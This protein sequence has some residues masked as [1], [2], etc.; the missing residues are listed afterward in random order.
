[1]AEPGRLALH[2]VRHV[3][4]RRPGDVLEHERQRG[5]ADPRDRLGARV[6]HV[7]QLADRPHHARAG[8]R[9]HRVLPAEHPRHRRRGHPRAGRHV[10]DGAA[11]RVLA[12]PGHP[13]LPSPRAVCAHPSGSAATRRATGSRTEASSGGGEGAGRRERR[14][15][16]TRPFTRHRSVSAIPAIASGPTRQHP[17]ISRAPAP[18]QPVTCSGGEGG[19]ARPGAGLGVPGL[20]A[21]GIDDDRLAGDPRGGL[22]RAVHVLGRTAVHADR[23]DLVR[24]GGQG[25]GLLQRLPG[26]GAVAGDACTTA[27]PARRARAPPA[28]APRPRRRP[29]PSPGPARRARPRPAPPAAGRWK[30]SSSATLSPYRPRY[31]EPSASI[32]PYGPTEA[33]THSGRATPC[34]RAP[35]RLAR[36]LHAAGASSSAARSAAD[37]ALGRSPRRWPGSWTVIATSAPASK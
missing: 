19:A 25:E 4:E 37:A 10:P 20:A 11:P 30:R 2:A 31:S 6:G 17:P 16:F 36:Q 34:A 29:E 22:D 9:A 23:D 21:V 35:R 1:M 7:V 12:L 24:V 5:R 3:R 15:T 33:A 14:G 18:R 28:A 32:A 8:R 27:R 26:P 13:A